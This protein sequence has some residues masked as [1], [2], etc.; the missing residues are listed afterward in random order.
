MKVG[1]VSMDREEIIDNLMAAIE[2]AVNHVPKKW[3]NIRCMYIKAVQSVAL[4]IYQVVPE[5]GMKID[6]GSRE[7]AEPLDG[8]VVQKR[9]GKS[10]EGK[11]KSRKKLV[12]SKK[13][14]GRI[15][16]VHYVGGEFVDGNEVDDDREG[17]EEQEN[18]DLGME[19][20]K[21]NKKKKDG[22][23]KLSKG[24]KAV[25]DEDDHEEKESGDQ[26][27]KLDTGKKMRKRAKK[28]V[29]SE[30]EEHGIIDGLAVDTIVAADV[31][32]HGDDK[33]LLLKMKV[34][35]K[36]KKGKK[37][38][39]HASNGDQEN[40]GPDDESNVMDGDDAIATT[41]NDGDHVDVDLSN[42]QKRVKNN[43]KIGNDKKVKKVKKT[44]L[45][46]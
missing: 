10:G 27:I 4:P 29:N 37:I 2:G 22:K 23:L 5:M 21:K 32:E 42:V 24:K 46:Q 43:E 31:D 13:R 34:K 33:E 7:E 44:K 41:A 28:I 17:V 1:R 9:D 40:L 3:A 19:K 11:E 45:R 18:D 30:V 12:G 6:I 26:F 20:K 14:K 38:S 35:N 8:I 15:H 16:D 25:I 39:L 36:S